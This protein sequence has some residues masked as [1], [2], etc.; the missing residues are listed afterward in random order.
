MG[1]A[2]LKSFLTERGY[3]VA[4][5]DANT[6]D[7][8]NEL[9]HRYVDKMRAWIPAEHQ[10]NF[11]NVGQEVL[12]N[13]LTALLNRQE[14]GDYF[15]LLGLL[16][17]ENFYVE[18][19]RSQLEELDAIASGFYT[20]LDDYV[21]RLLERENPDVLGLSVFRG[22]LGASL[23]AARLARKV[24]PGIKTVMGGAIFSQSLGL[25]TP[26]LDYFLQASA[27]VVDAL[28][29]GEGE[30]LFWQWLEGRLE[31][32]K[33][34]YTPADTRGELLDL[35]NAPL[36][37]YSGLDLAMYPH[38]AHYGS[39]SCPFEC[40]FCSETKYWGKY[41]KKEVPQLAGE[42]TDLSR[43]HK[44][45]L[46]LMCDS[47]LNPVISPLSQEME[48]RDDALYIDGYLRVGKESL[49]RSTVYQWRRG[50]FYRARLGIESGSPHVLQLMEKRI[51][52]DEIK[53]SLQNLADAGIKTTT[54]W[55]MGHPGETEEDFLK[56]LALIQDMKDHIYEAWCSTFHYFP[57]GQVN[58]NEWSA[59][60]R[61]L[62]PETFRPLLISLPE[63]L[64]LEPNRQEAFG[65]MNRFVEHC[66]NLGIPNPYTMREFHQ[67]D[68]R[69]KQ[70]HRNAVP[71]LV[72]FEN[73]DRR[74]D[75]CK[76][77]CEPVAAH[78]DL[79]DDGDFGF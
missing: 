75:E 36:P 69:W 42:L 76:A 71:P 7:S 26:D 23:A 10:G 30:H 47:L 74:I 61:L 24:K 72:D 63:A 58:S 73:P 62:Y 15:T 68:N 53:Q 13:H 3:E 55:V 19:E 46:V 9:Y 5:E 45:Q 44:S 17:K 66:R 14:D 70:L 37:D 21:E 18:L 34:I 51:A 78:T 43:R 22:N 41:R 2:C 28:I 79:P 8:F 32:D 54:Y 12:E 1:I 52:V 38:I 16:V 59:H 56:T 40:S 48:R 6:D 31:A 77:I 67:A 27:G 25:G 11:Y 65:R 49:D 64:D 35:S 50:G 57:T 39:R 4:I 33:R 20:M 60:S 29:I